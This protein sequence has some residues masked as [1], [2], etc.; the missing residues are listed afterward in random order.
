MCACV[1]AFARAGGPVQR[2]ARASAFVCVLLASEFTLMH[3]CSQQQPE[4]LLRV[5]SVCVLW[6]NCLRDDNL[7]SC[8]PFTHIHL[9]G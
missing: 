9:R 4:L 1:H 5:V 7:C 2:G 6:Q 3:M 8:L